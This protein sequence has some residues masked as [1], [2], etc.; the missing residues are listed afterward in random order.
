[1]NIYTSIYIML[2]NVFMTYTKT[3]SRPKIIDLNKRRSSRLKYI[4]ASI[5]R[6]NSFEATSE[7]SRPWKPHPVNAQGQGL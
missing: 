7:T 5:S 3:C 1:M 6:T 4:F 2:I